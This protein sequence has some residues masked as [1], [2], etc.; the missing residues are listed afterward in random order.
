MVFLSFWRQKH[1]QIQIMHVFLPPFFTQ[2]AISSLSFVEG[3]KQLPFVVMEVQ[4]R[5]LRASVLSLQFR[6]GVLL[7]VG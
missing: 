2:V 7:C 6:V 5:T 1:T 4:Y 3:A